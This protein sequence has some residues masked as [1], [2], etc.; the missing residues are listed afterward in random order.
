M[1]HLI[2][3]SQLKEKL[4]E[5]L[6]YFGNVVEVKKEMETNGVEA[7]LQASFNNVT[8]LQQASR[9]NSDPSL[10]W[11]LLQ[12]GANPNGNGKEDGPWKT[13]L[14][15]ASQA[16]MLPIMEL[17]LAYGADAD[18]Y[19]SHAL[20]EVFAGTYHSQRNI[21]R[22]LLQHGADPNAAD[23]YADNEGLRQTPFLRAVKFARFGLVR[24]MAKW[25][26]TTPN[27]REEDVSERKY[28][29][30]IKAEIENGKQERNAFLGE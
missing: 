19:H 2:I 20:R 5:D 29:K 26:N 18:L 16:G 1:N 3:T 24:E 6:C 7:V 17:L 22:M 4:V 25:M 12:R 30:H 21:A 9:Y 15:A 28:F 14:V 11:Y 10:V 27:I 23:S 13:P 8:C